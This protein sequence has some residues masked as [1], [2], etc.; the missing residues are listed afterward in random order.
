M[1][2]IKNTLVAIAIVAAAAAALPASAQWAGQYDSDL[3]QNSFAQSTSASKT[4]RAMASGVERAMRNADA[5][6]SNKAATQSAKAHDKAA[7]DVEHSFFS[8]ADTAK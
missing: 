5:S 8:K 6:T 1:K 7:N 2:S 3:F 4:E